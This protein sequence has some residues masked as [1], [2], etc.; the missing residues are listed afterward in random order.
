LCAC[1]LNNATV[2][3]I[4]GLETQGKHTAESHIP[5]EVTKFLTVPESA[6]MELMVSMNPI[7]NTITV[8][9]FLES[10]PDPVPDPA[11]K[12]SP[13]KQRVVQCAVS[14]TR[15]RILQQFRDWKEINTV[16][17]ACQKRC[18]FAS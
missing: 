3:S 14:K 8:Q 18:F 13:F 16:S 6:A 17:T 5:Y 1:S 9:H 15:E 11:A 10:L 4:F 7:A 2:E 12:M